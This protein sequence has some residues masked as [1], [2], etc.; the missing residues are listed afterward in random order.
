MAEDRS[1]S[2]ITGEELAER[3]DLLDDEYYEVLNQSSWLESK[4]S[5][6]GTSSASLA[7]QIDLAEE[8]LAR[9]A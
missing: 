7:R 8:A 9:L 2:E 4:V 5:E 3:S 6:G 1:L